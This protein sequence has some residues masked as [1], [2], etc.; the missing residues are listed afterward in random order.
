MRSICMGLGVIV[1]VVLVAPALAGFDQYGYNWAAHVFVGTGESWAMG[2]LGM[3][4][5]QAEAYMGIYAHDQIVMKWSLAWQLSE[6]GPDG[7]RG[8][9]DELPWTPNAWENNEWNGAVGK[10]WGGGITQGS[11][12]V[13]HYK[14][15][16]VGPSL[17]NSPHWHPGGY[18]IW[19]QFEVIMDQGTVDGIHEFLTHAIPCGYGA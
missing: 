18:A 5:A 2:K 14:I 1:L 4:H 16:W 10:E 9:G 15:I 3:I 6:F 8:S 7:I 19:G 17:E 13:W 12:E 11:G